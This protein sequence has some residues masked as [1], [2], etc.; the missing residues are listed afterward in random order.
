MTINGRIAVLRQREGL[1]QKCFG[2]LIERSESFVSKLESGRIQPTDEVVHLISNTFS[3]DEKWLKEGKGT[4]FI[5]SL[6]ER[7]RTAR[8]AY[9]Y[10]QKE[11]ADELGCSRNTISLIERGMVRPGEV[12]LQALTDKLW[13]DRKWLLTGQ[14]E[15]QKQE[16]T[17][18]YEILKT[19]PMV[20]QHFRRFIDRLDE[21]DSNQIE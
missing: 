18:F 12:L 19:D 13:I 6:T 15:M 7:I 10:T 20:R 2:R 1:S 11:L 3:V 9:S 4:L 21:S 5:T 16:L 17:Q 14:G 8:N